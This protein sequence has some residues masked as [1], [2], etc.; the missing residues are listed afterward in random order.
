M[1]SYETKND[2]WTSIHCSQF[3]KIGNHLGIHQMGV[4]FKSV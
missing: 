2:Y 4:V 3:N 1:Q